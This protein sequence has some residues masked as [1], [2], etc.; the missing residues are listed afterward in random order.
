MRISILKIML[1]VCGGLLGVQTSSAQGTFVNL[2]FESPIAPL[3]PVN[4]LVPASNAVPGWVVYT[5]GFQAQTVAYNALSLG[6]AEVSL[7]GPGSPVP[8]IQGNYTVVLQ[9]SSG[10][11]DGQ[12]SIAQT[13]QIP[14]NA[15]SLMFWGIVGPSDVAV[16]GQT[17]SLIVAGS[18][19]NYNIYE[20]DISGFAGRTEQL[21]FTAQPHSEDIIDNVMFST[22]PV[23]EPSTW[24][25][26]LLS[27][28]VVKL[29]R[30]IKGSPIFYSSRPIN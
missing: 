30:L 25:L 29:I 15:E 8:P 18:T 10:G 22:S 26:L 27:A 2:G 19:P 11:P 1:T 20:A 17:L 13:G 3:N 24:V 4:G 16:G 23:P 21:S 14:E 28:G 9:G 7:Q 5:Y 6:A 12:A